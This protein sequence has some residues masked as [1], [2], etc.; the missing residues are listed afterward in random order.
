MAAVS[1]AGSDAKAEAKETSRAVGGGAVAGAKVGL[2]II[3]EPF[4][5]L[6]CC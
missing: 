1:L 6:K 2:N 5:Y 4:L 3:V